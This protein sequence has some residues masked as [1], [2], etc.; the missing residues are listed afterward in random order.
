MTFYL[1][2]AAAPSFLSKLLRQRPSQTSRIKKEK[3][4]AFQ[5]LDADAL[6]LWKISIPPHQTVP[7]NLDYLQVNLNDVTLLLPIDELSEVFSESVAPK[8]IHVI[9]KSPT[10]AQQSKRAPPS[11][12]KP[13]PTDD[14]GTLRA[15][16]LKGTPAKPPPEGGTA[17]EFSKRQANPNQMIYCNV[18]L[19]AS[20]TIPVTLLHPIFGQFIDDCENNK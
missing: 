1:K 11:A 19:H 4:V 10:L 6:D 16:F 3:E 2:D 14:F 7:L 5:H 8:H 17:K 15:Q 18:P 20:A 13:P 9:V 12:Y